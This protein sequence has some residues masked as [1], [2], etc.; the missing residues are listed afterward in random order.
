MAGRQLGKLYVERLRRMETS[1]PESAS[2]RASDGVR[3]SE[4][5]GTRRSQAK[6]EHSTAN[7]AEALAAVAARIPVEAVGLY[8]AGVNIIGPQLA[9]KIGIAVICGGLAMV[10]KGLGFV[11]SVNSFGEKVSVRKLPLVE[12]LITGLAFVVWLGA[13]PNSIFTG[14]PGYT[15]QRGGWLLVLGATALVIIDRVRKISWSW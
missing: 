6:P 5:I 13:L 12:P 15:Q 3:G 8:I 11:E 14:V 10:L 9:G 4:R 7:P 1:E 2:A